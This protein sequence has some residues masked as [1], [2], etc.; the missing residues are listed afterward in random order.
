MGKYERKKEKKSRRGLIVAIVLVIA[1]ILLV[2]FVMPQILYRLNNG[3]DTADFSSTSA[4][5][6]QNSDADEESTGTG[7]G[8]TVSEE[9]AGAA[10][11]FPYLLE[12]GKLEVESIFQFDGINP[13]SGNQQGTNIAT[14]TIRNLSDAYLES[15]EL[16]FTTDTGDVLRFL[17]S[18][19]PAGQTVLAFSTD[20]TSVDKATE[21]TEITCAPVFNTEAS[22]HEDQVTVAVEGTKVTLKNNTNRVLEKIV[23]YCHASLGDQF[24]GGI[25]YTYTVTDL[26]AYETTEINAVDCFLGLAEVVRI[27]IVE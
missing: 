12:D 22:M 7:P 25:T 15:A 27:A 13:D 23:V 9:P 26:P 4:T 24:F 16:S 21:Y 17:V 20:N 3:G 14:I 6:P 5:E 8:E 2:L 1:A 10:L 11:E 19:L 18:D